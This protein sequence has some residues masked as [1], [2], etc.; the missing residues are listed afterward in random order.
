[1]KT[2]LEYSSKFVVHWSLTYWPK[3]VYLFP[4]KTMGMY[5]SFK[6]YFSLFLCKSLY[7]AMS[8]SEE[9]FLNVFSLSLW[10]CHPQRGTIN[11]LRVCIGP[12]GEFVWNRYDLV[13]KGVYLP[14]ITNYYLIQVFLHNS[15]FLIPRA[16]VQDRPG[17][18]D[19]A[20]ALG[21]RHLYGDKGGTA[22][23]SFWRG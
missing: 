15:R 2:H 13:Y 8:F 16:R 17:S 9:N 12:A 23:K 19:A 22:K 7:V 5:F 4:S 1:M 11:L 6:K 14:Y 10:Y 21:I 3:I 20:P 18:Q